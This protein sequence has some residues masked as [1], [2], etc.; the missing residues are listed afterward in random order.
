MD[1]NLS[2]LDLKLLA[3]STRVVQNQPTPIWSRVLH[4]TRVTWHNPN[5]V[6]W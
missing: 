6:L 3:V 2:N 4:A 1:Q 5:K